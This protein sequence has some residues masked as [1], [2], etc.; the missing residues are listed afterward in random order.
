MGKQ[1]GNR[2]GPAHGGPAIVSAPDPAPQRGLCF[3]FRKWDRLRELPVEV[4]LCSSFLYVDTCVTSLFISFSQHHALHKVTDSKT[5]RCQRQP[6]SDT[7]SAHIY[8][9]EFQWIQ[10]MMDLW[11]AV[12][13]TETSGRLWFDHKEVT[14]CK[15]IITSR[16]N[17]A[18]TDGQTVGTTGCEKVQS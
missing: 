17:R 4:H 7:G 12:I 1:A 10:G 15:P 3:C 5:Q 18:V 14:V 11:L 13:S 2:P 9:V 6:Q 16:N 8:P